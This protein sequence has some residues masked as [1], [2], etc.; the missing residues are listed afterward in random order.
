MEH[1][2]TNETTFS[3]CSTRPIASRYRPQVT[4]R[5]TDECTVINPHLPPTLYRYLM[6]SHHYSC[7]TKLIPRLTAFSRELLTCMSSGD[8]QDRWGHACQHRTAYRSMQTA[9][10]GPCICLPETSH[11]GPTNKHASLSFL[12]TYWRWGF[13]QI[14]HSHSFL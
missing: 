10:F 13:C 12:S 4:F 3:C 9:R 2:H 1:V 5:S 6:S 14:T 7:I 8:L 11:Q